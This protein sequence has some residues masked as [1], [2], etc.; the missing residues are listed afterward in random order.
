MELLLVLF[1]SLLPIK[2]IYYFINR[3]RISDIVV[4]VLFRFIELLL[5]SVYFTKINFYFIKH[6]FIIPKLI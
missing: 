1:I 3:Y 2:Y 4:I 5:C 6:I